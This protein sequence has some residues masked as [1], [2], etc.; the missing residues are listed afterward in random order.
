MSVPKLINWIE[1]NDPD[2]SYNYWN[3]EE[4]EKKKIFYVDEN[5]SDKKLSNNKHLDE[6]L[7]EFKKIIQIYNLNFKN[8][9]IFSLGA[10]TG[11]IESNVLK[12][13]RFKSLNLLDFSKHRILSLAPTTVKLNIKNLSNIKFIHGNMYDLKI[14]NASVDFFILAQSFHHADEPLELLKIIK[15]KLKKD[16]TIIIIGEPYYSF[17]NTIKHIGY[18]FI[19]YFL[20]YKK[21]RKIHYFLPSYNDIFPPDQIKGDNHYSIFD[22]HLM[23]KKFNFKYEKTLSRSK[24]TQSFIL[25]NL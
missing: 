11:W 21:Y 13:H 17:I 19:K 8:K 16:G 6:I 4:E 3:N 12:G 20:N 14:N 7:K 5:S 24:K 9:D 18:H 1:Q 25:S 2:K 23:F 22:Y 10:G 15:K